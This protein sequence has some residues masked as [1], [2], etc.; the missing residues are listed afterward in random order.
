MNINNND[1]NRNNIRNNINNIYGSRFKKIDPKEAE[2]ARR[3]GM[4]IEDFCAL[5]EE[6][7][8]RK[9]Q[10]YNE[11]HPENPIPYKGQVPQNTE[12]ERFKN[13]IDWS[14]IRLQ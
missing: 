10:A 13:D 11:K 12:L 14:K 6:E 2:V 5:S 4:S 7:K 9:V 3:L 8:M 1:N